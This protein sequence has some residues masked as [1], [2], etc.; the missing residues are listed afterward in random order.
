MNAS[1]VANLVTPRHI[2]H[3]TTGSGHGPIVRLMS[4]SDYGQLI[5]PFVFLD[6]FEGPKSF[7]GSMPMHP[8]SGIA[9]V[10][11]VTE[12]NMHFDDPEA[13]S[14]AIAYGG[15]EWMRAGGGVWHGKEMSAGTSARVQGFQLW[16]ALGP[17][18][19]NGQVDSQYLEADTMPSAGLARVI[20]GRYE[21]VQSPVR[22]P[23]GINYLL[24]TIPAG[25]SWTYTP[26]QGHESLWMSLSRGSVSSPDSIVA[27]EMVIF[28]RGSQAVILAAGATGATFVLGSAV[29]HP[30][31]LKL[32]YYSVHTNDEALRAGEANIAEIGNRLRQQKQ[33]D[34]RSTS[35]PVFK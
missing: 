23:D 8:H 18:L 24:V 25:E 14:G 12:G 15:V 1:A 22:A 16:L 29:P 17:E 3:R 11:V 6:L 10:T 19:E 33:S 27:G 9:T 34:E 2:S 7:L 5:K 20:V 30:Y 21:G 32:G 31:D 26:P 4:P 35:V 28:E 13:G